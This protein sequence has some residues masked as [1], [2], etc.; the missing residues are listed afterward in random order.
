MSSRSDKGQIYTMEGV[1]AAFIILGV[2]LFII[3]ANSLV[4][5][6]TEKVIDMKLGE[7]SNDVLMSLD[8][9]SNDSWSTT[10]S[11]K[12]YVAGWNGHT[13]IHTNNVPDA[14]IVMLNSNI[15]NML[16]QDGQYTQGD[17][18]YNLEFFYI[19]S[20]GKHSDTVLINGEPGDNSM[21]ATR[22][23]TLN[24][25]DVGLSTFWENNARFP[26]VVQVKIICWHL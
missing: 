26:Q 14:G 17:V 11:L 8:W 15:S 4:V 18:Q 20:T 22:L 19:N 16:F 23:V 5:P 7:L 10:G 1:T 21:V 12:S 25:N 3:E 24:E 9:S 6:Q 13:V 2:L